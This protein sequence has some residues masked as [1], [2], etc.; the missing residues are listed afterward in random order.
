MADPAGIKTTRLSSGT[1]GVALPGE[2]LHALGSAPLGNLFR[3]VDDD[4]AEDT[5]RAAWECGV[6]VFDTAPHYGLGLA[7]KRLGA[8]LQSYPR[9]EYMIST[10]VGRLLRPVSPVPDGWDPAGFLVCP[11]HERVIDFSRDGVL[12]SLEQSLQ[13]L[14]VDTID[15]VYVHDPNDHYR[16]ALE[17]ALPALAELKSQG[18]IRHFGA[19]MNQSRML[20]DFVEH[21]DLDIVLLAGRYTLLDQTALDDLLPLVAA[22]SV[23]VVAAGVF[24]SG[25][26]ASERPGSNATFDYVRAPQELVR[27][28]TEI[29]EIC[30]RHS[31]TLPQAAVQMAA[32]HPAVVSVCVGA[33]SRQEVERNARLFQTPVPDSL[34]AE[35]RT[36]GLI[37]GRTA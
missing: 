1:R 11:D 30:E 31:V 9:S 17:G 2:S 35:L 18:V 26:L 5:V 4:A 20:A 16:D 7:E 10:K 14:G 6:R 34:W 33:R 28:A 25:I 22:R 29:A 12:R 21:S 3:E 37:D 19:G 23:A 24:N 15:I 13:R 27:R 32:R 36:R 8:A